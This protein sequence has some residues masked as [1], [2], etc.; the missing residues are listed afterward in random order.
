MNSIGN[1]HYSDY[2]T[3]H[4]IIDSKEGHPIR[5]QEAVMEKK[6]KPIVQ[7]GVNLFSIISYLLKR[8]WNGCNFRINLLDNIIEYYK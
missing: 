2:V 7:N 5:V 6:P 1:R 4:C 3:E 8:F